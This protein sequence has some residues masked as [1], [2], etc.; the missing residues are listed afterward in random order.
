MA[1]VLQAWTGFGSKE[2][3]IAALRQADRDLVVLD[4]D[5]H[6]HERIPWSRADLDALRAGAPARRV[7]AYLSIGEAETYRDYWH[8]S[9]DA[10][11]DGTPDRSAPRFLCAENPDWEGNYKV[12]YWLPDWQQLMLRDIET[13]ASRGFDGLYL[14]IVDGFQYF[15]E[16]HGRRN[17]ETGRGYREDMI[18]WVASVATH[19]R[20]RGLRLIVPQNASELLASPR[21]RE[22][23]DGIAVE[24][25][26]AMHG[27]PQP[28]A[29]TRSILDDLAPLRAAGKPVLAVEYGGSAIRRLAARRARQHGI[30]VL[31]TDLELTGLGTTY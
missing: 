18:A 6:A 14:D 1:Y 27:K 13:I 10:D 26:F 19:A 11:S 21:Y 29:E 5:F 25:L 28:A 8:K 2:R 31:V 24:E 16:R 20:S 23:I 17:R 4:R 30:A 3:T 15:E 12:R 7:L 9:W 22:L